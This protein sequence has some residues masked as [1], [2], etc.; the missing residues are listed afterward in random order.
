MRP[1]TRISHVFWISAAIALTGCQNRAPSLRMLDT[2]AGYNEPY[3]DEEVAIYERAHSHGGSFGRTL[4]PR[5]AKVYVYPH[6]LPSQDYFLGGY[7]ALVTRKDE[8]V[9]DSIETPSD[10]AIQDRLDESH[11]AP[12]LRKRRKPAKPRGVKP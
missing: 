12:I 6:E 9:F 5:I 2:R 10:D 1:F 7:I 3:D 8:V 4:G 11:A